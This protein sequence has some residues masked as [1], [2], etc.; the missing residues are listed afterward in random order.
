MGYQNKATRPGEFN[1]LVATFALVGTDGSTSKLGDIKAA[2]TTWDGSTLYFISATGG[3]DKFTDP[4]L[5]TKFKKFYFLNAA[6]SE[7][8][9]VDE[10]WYQVDD[11]DSEYLMNDRI[12]LPYGQGFVFDAKDAGAQLCF[13]GEVKNGTTIKPVPGKF[14]M[15]GNVTPVDLKL[16]DFTCN[17]TTWDGSTVY[18]ISTTGGM[19]KFTDEDLGTKFKKFYFLNTAESVEYGVDPGWYQVDDTDSE[20]LMNDKIDMPA[21]AGIVFDAKDAGAEFIVPKVIK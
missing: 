15:V 14:N 16:G 2:N 9:G 19:A 21:G 17:N 3:M 5:G 1:A 13:A 6:E 8:Y 7:E 10:G 18:F 12:D 20:Y 4:D 11:T